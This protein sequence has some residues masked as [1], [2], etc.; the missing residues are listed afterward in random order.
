V[1]GAEIGQQLGDDARAE[2]VRPRDKP[3]KTDV[4]AHLVA[5][6]PD[7]FLMCGLAALD[8]DLFGVRD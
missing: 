5:P 1:H 7:G 3:L 6:A 2:G 4:L 8:S